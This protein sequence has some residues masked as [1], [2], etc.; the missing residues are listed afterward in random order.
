[1][2]STRDKSKPT[3]YKTIQLESLPLVRTAKLPK[4]FFSRQDRVS[5][6]PH[7]TQ[8]RDGL[9][10]TFR[11]KMLN[12]YEHETDTLQLLDARQE[13]AVTS[14]VAYKGIKTFTPST[15]GDVVL[16]TLKLKLYLLKI[17]K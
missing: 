5:Y 11:E 9:F 2:T 16:V 6:P 15:D 14:K 7:Y 8:V 1:M 12:D 3:D 10:V 4:G 13:N 17:I